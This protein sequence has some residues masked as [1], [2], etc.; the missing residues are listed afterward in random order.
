MYNYEDP[1]RT[2]SPDDLSPIEEL[3]MDS[4]SDYDRGEYDCLHGY[5]AELGKSDK[6]YQGYGDQYHFEQNQ[7]KLEEIA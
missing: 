7:G 3:I 1:N 6:Y 5:E 4:L 2:G